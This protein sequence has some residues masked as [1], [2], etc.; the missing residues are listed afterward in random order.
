MTYYVLLNYKGYGNEP[1]KSVCEATFETY[2]DAAEYAK[3]FKGV[4]TKILVEAQD[5][6]A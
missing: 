1:R 3:T 4:Q 2:A 6:E 5:E